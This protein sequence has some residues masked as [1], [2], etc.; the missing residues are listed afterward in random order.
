MGS[1]AKMINKKIYLIAGLIVA[2]IVVWAARYMFLYSQ[3]MKEI[4]FEES[5]KLALLC[6]DNP[7]SQ[8]DFGTIYAENKPYVQ[9]N[10]A[11]GELFFIANN[12][13]KA[14][15]LSPGYSTSVWIGPIEKLSEWTVQSGIEPITEVK[16]EI[17]KNKY[18]KVTLGAGNYWISP[19][20][21]ADISVYSCTPDSLTGPVINSVQ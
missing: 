14:S 12:V 15:V 18:K 9:F 10:T 20:I 19:A 13:G 6:N 17:F 11:G 7:A 16:F 1:L 4:T 5:P 21:G 3:S 8:I 2:L